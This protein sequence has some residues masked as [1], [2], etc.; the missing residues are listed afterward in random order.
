[1]NNKVINVNEIYE[2]IELETAATTP[3][4]SMKIKFNIVLIKMP[5]K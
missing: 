1:M 3:Y 5:K 2:I 4:F